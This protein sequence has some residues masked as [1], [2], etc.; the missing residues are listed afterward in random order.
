MFLESIILIL[1][2]FST[3]KSDIFSAKISPNLLDSYFWN[4]EK[5]Y[6]IMI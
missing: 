6:M 1:G 3:T 2:M 4:Y 5:I